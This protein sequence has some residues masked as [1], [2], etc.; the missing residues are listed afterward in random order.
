MIK[1]G[2]GSYIQ[3]GEWEADDL[4][5]FKASRY[6]F[7]NGNVGIGTA[8][9]QHKLDV[10]GN[11]NVAGNLNSTTIRTSNLTLDLNDNFTY[12][13]QI[14]GHY[15]LKWTNDSWHLPGASLWLS[16]YAGMKFFTGGNP[17]PRFVITINGNVGIGTTAPQN[18]LD[19][20]GIIRAAEVKIETGW[21]D[22]VFNDDYRLKPL[23]ELE[24]FIKAN[25]HLPEI[26][27][28]IEVKENKGI[29]IGEMQTKLL[30]KIEELTLYLI[31]QENTIQEL[32]KEIRELKEK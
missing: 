1:I 8:N 6:N 27:S 22:F 17:D 15:A 16:G 26:P 14:M 13:G 30:Q 29:G 11:M 23:S 10:A 28:A 18:K 5:S 32:K 25:R 21:A 7:T 31:Q 12:D 20:N 24:T 3:I 2:D 4:L 19:V 9:P